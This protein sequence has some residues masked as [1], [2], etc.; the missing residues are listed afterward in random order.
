MRNFLFLLLLLVGTLMPILT[1]G[2]YGS[3]GIGNADGSESPVGYPQPRLL[4]WLDGS[5]V[6]TTGSK[7]TQWTDKSGNGHHFTPDAV[8]NRPTF[9]ASGGPANRPYLSFDGVE[10]RLVCPS[11]EF[12]SSGYS[13]FFVVKSNDNKYG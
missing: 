6:M 7:V 10:N 5:E 8:A 11:F 4:L 1:M 13:I 12:P 2:Q 3:M 9:H